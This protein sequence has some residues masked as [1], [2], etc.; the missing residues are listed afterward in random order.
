VARVP[1]VCG[2]AASSPARPGVCAG[3]CAISQSRVPG[4]MVIR[5]S[6]S[7]APQQARRP[8][9]PPP[10]HYALKLSSHGPGRDH[11]TGPDQIRAHGL[12]HP[13]HE[14]YPHAQ[15]F[16]ARDDTHLSNETPRACA[17]WEQAFACTDTTR[18]CIPKLL[19]SARRSTRPHRRHSALGPAT[20]GSCRHGVCRCVWRRG[21]RVAAAGRS[22]SREEQHVI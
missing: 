21:W 19:P 9:V 14:T 3:L 17:A 7:A 5:T 16:P 11:V 15:R 10:S 22:A 8:T 6:A 13:A 18:P 1:G 2:F 20:D 12:P 4:R